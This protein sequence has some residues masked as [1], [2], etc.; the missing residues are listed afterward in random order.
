MVC[1]IDNRHGRSDGAALLTNGDRSEMPISP[2]LSPSPVT[3]RVRRRV[4]VA[5]LPA[6]DLFHIL[7][8]FRLVGFRPRLHSVQH[9]FELV[10]P[11]AVSEGNT[12]AP[13]A[14]TRPAMF[15]GRVVARQLRGDRV[16]F[17]L[18]QQPG[19][20]SSDRGI[21]VPAALHADEPGYLRHYS[22]RAA[23]LSARCGARRRRAACAWQRRARQTAF[24]EGP[25]L[26]RRT[27][28]RAARDADAVARR[29]VGTGNRAARDLHRDETVR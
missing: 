16:V 13:R 28:G 2:S 25:I 14:T 4:I 21:R 9:L 7:G 1:K 15:G 3:S 11:N 24:D 20:W 26:S 12:P 19:R 29:S 6:L 27:R 8:K 10:H 22:F 5:G 23:W 17:P 18:L